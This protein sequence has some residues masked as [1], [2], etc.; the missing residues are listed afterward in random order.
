MLS[1][2]IYLIISYTKFK[3]PCSVHI[4]SMIGFSDISLFVITPIEIPND[5]AFNLLGASVQTL[6]FLEPMFK[7]LLNVNLNVCP[8]DHCI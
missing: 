3:T 8:V 1:F 4:N 5:P 6:I 2:I 7:L